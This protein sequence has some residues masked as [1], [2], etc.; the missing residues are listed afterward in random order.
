MQAPPQFWESRTMQLPV[1]GWDNAP[2]T[3]N[4]YRPELDGLRAIAVLLVACY[5]I[6]LGTISG[7]VD[8]FLLLTGFF[9][10]ASL[11]RMIERYGSISLGSYFGRLASRL[12]PTAATV[13]LVSLL[14]T[15]FFL[16][17]TRWRAAVDEVIASALY[18]QNWKLAFTSTDYLSDDQPASIVQHFWSIS[19]QGQF[20]ILW[21]LLFMLLVFLCGSSVKRIRTAALVSFGL[22]FGLSFLYSVISTA[23]NNV[24]AYFD[25]GTRLWEFALGATLALFITSIKIP[26]ELRLVFGWVGLVALVSCGLLVPNSEMFP[27]YIA[28]WPTVAALLIILA[29]SSNSKLGV[30]RFLTWQPVK[31]LGGLAYGIFLWHWPLF[32]TF[33]EISGQNTAGL[34]DGLGIIAL[35]IILAYFTKKILEDGL[36]SILP[37]RGKAQ[38]TAGLTVGVSFLIPVLVMSLTWTQIIGSQESPNVSISSSSSDDLGDYPGAQVFQFPELAGDV[39]NMPVTPDPASA[40]EDVPDIYNQGCHADIPDSEALKCHFG[41][42]NDPEVTLAVVGASRTAHWLPAIVERAEENSWQVI[43]I[44]K[45]ACLLSLGDDPMYRDQPYP[46]CTDWRENAIDELIDI[47]PDLVITSSTRTGRESE[48]VPGGYIEVWNQLDEAGLSV[49]GIRDSPVVDGDVVDCVAT[50]DLEDCVY[51][52]DFYPDSDPAADSDEVP[53]NLNPIDLTDQ[54]CPDLE[55]SAV[56]GNVLVYRDGRHLTASYSTTLAPAMEEKI[57]EVL[58]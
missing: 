32:I 33:R 35:S 1:V 21:A 36:R 41:E 40:T 19:I 3:S 47:D 37:K 46:Q 7:G 38:V 31:Y 9:I 30:D 45:S 12:I 57:L 5:H 23:N 14:L 10:T 54:I 52:V 42:L 39:P 51:D 55:C 17:N 4:Y 27:G 44:T 50:G 18:Y 16:P 58:N 53:D 34:F 22:I 28:L 48:W 8:V 11:M 20:Y 49:L 2:K 24:W 29:G 43:S 56:I 13:L 6:W 15:M 26:K 25:T